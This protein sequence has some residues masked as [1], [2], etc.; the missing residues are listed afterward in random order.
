MHIQT[1]IFLKEPQVTGNML[2]GKV[3]GQM[4]STEG[5]FLFIRLPFI[6]FDF[7]SYVHIT[8]IKEESAY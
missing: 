4:R 3:A 1:C 5:N 8:F 2:P 7:Y 6:L